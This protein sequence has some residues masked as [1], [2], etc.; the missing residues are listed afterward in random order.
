[1]GPGR[2][3]G[4]PRL[5]LPLLIAELHLRQGDR[6]ALGEL[7]AAA[8]LADQMIIYQICLGAFTCSSGRP[9]RRC[10]RC[11]TPYRL[12]PENGSPSGSWGDLPE[13]GASDAADICYEHAGVLDP[14]DR[15]YVRRFR[16]AAGWSE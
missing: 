11:A 9:S 15:D 4:T 7:E 5:F 13:A 16:S 2:G 12:R 8:R 6:S 14:Y 1:M 3:V 10:A